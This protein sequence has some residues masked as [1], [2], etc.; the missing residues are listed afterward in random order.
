MTTSFTTNFR[1]PIPDFMSEPWHAQLQAAIQAVDGLVYK[2][3]VAVNINLWLHATTYNIGNIAIDP[4]DGSTWLC[5]VGNVSAS[6]V[7]TFAQD[8]AA[9]PTYWAAFVST[10]NPRGA[11]AN[12]TTYAYYDLVYDATLKIIALCTTAY[13]S[14]A[15]PA[16]LNTEAA[17]WAFL[18]VFPVATTAASI[19][20]D[21]TA[22]GLAAITAQA[23][24]D[25]D[26]ADLIAAI[27]TTTALTALVATKAPLAS[28][29]LT[30]NPTAPTQ[31]PNDNSTKLST[32]AYAAAAIAAILPISS[33]NIADAAITPRKLFTSVIGFANTMVNGVLTQTQNAGAQTFAIKTL[34]SAGAAD[35]SATD[36]VFIAFRGTSSVSGLVNV[37]MVTAALSITIPA[38]QG[39]GFTNNVPGRVWIGALNNAGVVELYVINALTGTN[40]YPLQGWGIFANT[41]AVVGAGS[42]GVPYS[43]TARAGVAYTV[44]G[45]YTWEA[46]GTLA[47]AGTWGTTPTRAS[48]Y[49]PGTVP[50]PGQEIQRVR[51]TSGAVSGVGAT[52]TPVDDTIPQ[53]TEGDQYMASP[54]LTPISSANVVDVVCQA[55]VSNAGTGRQVGALFQDATANAIAV[56]DTIGSA[57]QNCIH[58]LEYEA[59][60]QILTATVFK[61]RSG[62]SA[63]NGATFNGTG[64]ARLFGGAYN[65]FIR[66]REIQA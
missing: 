6:G 58:H 28:P 8:R 43:T 17:N 7:T 55:I 31:A 48:L 23:A 14:G 35:P 40:I 3:L 52:V 47:A 20:Y 5:K 45:Y 30:G 12:N 15:G 59:Q 62:N 34:A 27:A 44:L 25:E 24:I 32:T 54:S 26:H 37:I 36:P 11:Y 39:I 64:G 2:A 41:S 13:T 33:A 66:V 18:A 19:S 56:D 38:G 46:G 9:H 10:I 1:I 53:I 29:A 60:L 49:Q 21:H 22:S 65:S 16:N 57:G 50:L 4:V 42:S 63:G 51:F 61:F